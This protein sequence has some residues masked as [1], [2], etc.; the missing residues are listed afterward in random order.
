VTLKPRALFPGARLAVVAPASP[1]NRKEFEDGLAELKRLEF[2]PV[3]DDDVFARAAPGYVAGSPELRAAAIRRALRDPSIHGI[4][5]TRGGYGSAQILPLLDVDEFR[6]ADKPFIGYSDL[7][8]LL[9]LFTIQCGVTAF[10]GPTLDRLSRREAG[11]DRTSLLAALCQ[12]EPTGEMAPDGLEA[13]R[14]GDASGVLLGGTMTQLVASLGTPWAFDPPHG[15]VLLLEEVGERP[16]RLDRMVTQL[17]QAGVLARAVAVV[18]GDLPG[19][20]EPT[21]TPTARSVMS[22]LF[23]DFHG[24]VVIGLPIGHTS[25][26]ALTLPLGVSCRVV[27]GSQCRLVIEEG[28]VE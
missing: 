2:E 8:A 15:Y 20:D 10:H 26:P 7:T 24:P 16:Y 3:Y 25:A 21:G 1:L 17:H 6:E 14:A 5:G 27:A 19:C 13:I 12:R 23:A 4:I 18:I 11:Y 28:A 22:H 9:T